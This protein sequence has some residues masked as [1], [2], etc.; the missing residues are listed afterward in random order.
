MN[1]AE[2][3]SIL[4][5][6]NSVY[7]I[8]ACLLLAVSAYLAIFGRALK[9]GENDGRLLLALPQAIFSSQAVSIGGTLYLAR[10]GD[11]FINT[12][13]SQ[14]FEFVE[15]AGAG[16]FFRKDGRPYISTSRQY[17][18]RFRI[19]TNPMPSRVIID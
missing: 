14:G 16:Y 4:S 13:E 11:A 18:S 6:K 2:K 17:S 5:L 7:L 19:F 9:Q 1:Q 8:I 15:Q 3:K 12:M 10:D